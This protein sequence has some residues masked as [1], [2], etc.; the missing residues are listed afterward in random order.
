M[1]NLNQ[2]VKWVH[3]QGH[4]HQKS[5]VVTYQR[6]LVVVAGKVTQ[7]EIVASFSVID[8]VPGL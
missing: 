1:I 3:G 5:R 7:G 4:A 6:W 8:S 2:T